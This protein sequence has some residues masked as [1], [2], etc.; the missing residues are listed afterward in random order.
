MARVRDAALRERMRRLEA[1]WPVRGRLQRLATVL[2]A[3]VF[4]ALLTPMGCGLTE[5]LCSAVGLSFD[6]FVV[7]SARGFRRLE[8]VRQRPSTPLLQFLLWRLRRQ[9]AASYEDAASSVA[10]RRRLA[11][12]V[13]E[14][15]QKEG[16]ELLG[17]R[18]AAYSS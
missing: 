18:I 16:V 11:E 7:A 1:S 4:K 6:G 15:L 9:H 13:L 17:P 10:K 14:R 2:R 12:I 8:D 5:A 3:L